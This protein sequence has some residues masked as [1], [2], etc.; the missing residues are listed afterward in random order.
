[1]R[2][3]L[4]AAALAVSAIGAQVAMATGEQLFESIL[5]RNTDRVAALIAGGDNVNARLP[6]GETPIMA[7][8]AVGAVDIM[9]ILLRSGADLTAKDELEMTALIH[10]AVAGQDEAA[11]FILGQPAGSSLVNHRDVF[12]ATALRAAIPSGNVTLVQALLSA[13]ADPNVPDSG[14]TT[15]LNDCD[16][17]TDNPVCEILVQ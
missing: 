15:A 1:M 6:T 14:R 10:A 2:R 16:G 4:I 13:G 8:A 11:A 7:A 9:H 17:V 3:R 5:K 12:G